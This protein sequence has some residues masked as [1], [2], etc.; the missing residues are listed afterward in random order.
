MNKQHGNSLLKLLS[1]LLLTNEVVA[2]KPLDECVGRLL[3]RYFEF[4]VSSLTSM[5]GNLFLADDPPPAPSIDQESKTFSQETDLSD[6]SKWHLV[7]CSNG[8]SLQ[9]LDDNKMEK[10]SFFTF[11]YMVFQA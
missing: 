3:D 2:N 4:N 8:Q 11:E 1:N 10:I 7:R 9:N 6:A 5:T